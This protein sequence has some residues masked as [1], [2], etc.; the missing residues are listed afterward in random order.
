MDLDLLDMNYPMVVSKLPFEQ[1]FQSGLT[2]LSCRANRV[3]PDLPNSSVNRLSHPK[4]VRPLCQT[5]Q[6][7]FARISQKPTHQNRSDIF[8]KTVTPVSPR[9]L[10]L[11]IPKLEQTNSK[12]GETW[13]RASSTK[14]R[15]L[16]PKIGTGKRLTCGPSLVR[17]HH[18]V[19]GFPQSI[20]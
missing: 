9:E 19:R 5:G 11:K 12:L 2:G 18:S 6:T 17:E 20:R 7:G 13:T 4:P 15:L 10:K 3:P 16:T 1:L 8:P 14:G